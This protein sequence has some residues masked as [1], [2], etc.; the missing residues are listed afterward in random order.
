MPQDGTHQGTSYHRLFIHVFCTASPR[1]TSWQTFVSWC[2]S[3]SPS[4]FLYQLSLPSFLSMTPPRPR[5]RFC[6]KAFGC[7]PLRATSFLD[8]RVPLLW[9]LWEGGGGIFTDP[10]YSE[11]LPFALLL[12]KEVQRW[13]S[14]VRVSELGLRIMCCI[15][16]SFSRATLWAGES[17]C[18]AQLP[19]GI[20]R[21]HKCVQ[22]VHLH[23]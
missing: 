21:P 17:D 22:E 7:V 1:W 12:Q 6:S 16:D 9:W 20:P 2:I 13:K 18:S 11:H 5:L 15:S 8:P 10:N 19:C 23:D 3:F 4:P 14:V